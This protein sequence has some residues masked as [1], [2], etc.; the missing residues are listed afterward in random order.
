MLDGRLEAN[1]FMENIETAV[2]WDKAVTLS[3]RSARL[4]VC[5]SYSQ[6]PVGSVEQEAFID[7]GPTAK[8][9]HAP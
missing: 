9:V 3:E 8:V 1:R 7:D 4:K 2:S 6:H 5:R